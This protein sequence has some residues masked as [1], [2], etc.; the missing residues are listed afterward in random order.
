MH[1][2]AKDLARVWLVKVRGILGPYPED[3][4]DISILNRIVKWKKMTFVTK[5]IADMWK[6]WRWIW[7]W[8]VANLSQLRVRSR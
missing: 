5:Q 8:K 1:E 6:H 2:I 7:A 3:E 4:K